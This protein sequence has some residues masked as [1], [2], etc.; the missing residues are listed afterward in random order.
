MEAEYMS[1][2]DATREAIA[3]HQFFKDL[4]ILVNN[5]ILHSDNRAALS[6]AQNP[7]QY[8][9][10]KH[11]A[12]RYHFIRARQSISPIHLANPSRQSISPIHL[13]N[14]NLIAMEI[15]RGVGSNEGCSK[16]AARIHGCVD[17]AQTTHLGQRRKTEKTDP[18][19]DK[20]SKI[21]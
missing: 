20:G 8:Q 6:I 13:A 16:A 9:R 12:I 5:P 21:K 14:A 15:C 10:S 17:M 2:S 7:V 4:Q 3:R 11:I 18:E 1:L 19:G